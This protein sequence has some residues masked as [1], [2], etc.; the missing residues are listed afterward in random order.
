MI[1]THLINDYIIIANTG[2]NFSIHNV[3]KIADQ[4][5]WNIL[6]GNAIQR[7]WQSGIVQFLAESKK[8]NCAVS[9]WAFQTELEYHQLCALLC[10]DFD[11]TMLL[12][13]EEGSRKF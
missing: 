12:I 3:S 2:G 1:T 4:E 8:Q 9:V 6:S 5:T 10:V 13:K 11:A 7:D